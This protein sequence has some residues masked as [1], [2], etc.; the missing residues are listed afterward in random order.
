M[1]ALAIRERGSGAA[2]F[3]V[4]VARVRGSDDHVVFD[5]TLRA[6]CEAFVAGWLAG[7]KDAL[8]LAE[9][10]TDSLIEAVAGGED[11]DAS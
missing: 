7:T 2:R 5:S 4:V 6:A 11:S 9:T 1:K 8:E 10:M 3:Y